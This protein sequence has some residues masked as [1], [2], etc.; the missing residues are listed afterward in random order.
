MKVLTNQDLVE[1]K[2]ES[3]LNSVF[4]SIRKEWIESHINN[5]NVNEST[6]PDDIIHQGKTLD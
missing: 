6:K 2:T 1:I 3:E 4:E 5:A